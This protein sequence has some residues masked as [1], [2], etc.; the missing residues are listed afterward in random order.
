MAFQEDDQP[1]LSHPYY[2]DGSGGSGAIGTT[3]ERRSELTFAQNKV[4]SEPTKGSAE[5]TLNGVPGKRYPQNSRPTNPTNNTPA[6]RSA[7]VS[8]IDLVI[9]IVSVT[10]VGPGFRAR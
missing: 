5:S 7:A 2:G 1:R 10:A 3:H 6:S 4:T 9:D 8:E